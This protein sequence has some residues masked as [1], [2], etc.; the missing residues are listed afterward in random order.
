MT[1]GQPVP[2]K[3]SKNLKIQER[4]GVEREKLTKRK[5]F[6]EVG[7]EVVNQV[8]RDRVAS[9]ILHE[10]LKVQA[11]KDPLTGLL[12][13]RGFEERAGTEI[14]RVARFRREL[15]KEGKEEEVLR[16][17]NLLVWMDAN[18]LKIINDTRGH[19]GGN[20]YLRDIAS[21]LK[22]V[23]ER[24]TDVIARFGGD[25]YAVLLGDFPLQ[26]AE[27]WWEKVDSLFVA[28]GI[29]I[30]GGI[31]DVGSD[32]LER[33]LELADEALYI[34]KIV[35][36]EQGKNLILSHEEATRIARE[37]NIEIKKE[38]GGK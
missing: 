7:P 18:N 37:R 29:S 2:I 21:L 12:N 6:Q 34:A 13:R 35:S 19:A 24:P 31:V 11:I 25:E 28:G 14:K 1:E 20:K 23:T 26:D 10:R 33:A 38:H 8:A 16:H 17:R 9:G 4:V 15:L 30:S 5:A 3:I 22:Q 36:K 27:G 32:S